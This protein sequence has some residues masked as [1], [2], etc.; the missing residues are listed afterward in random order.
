MVARLHASNGVEVINPLDA[1]GVG[2][3]LLAI[4]QAMSGPVHLTTAGYIML[5]RAVMERARKGDRTATQ[6]KKRFKGGGGRHP[7]GGPA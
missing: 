3:E 2:E 4:E 5:A 1:L 6:Q 7:T